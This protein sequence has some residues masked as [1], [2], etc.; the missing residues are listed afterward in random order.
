MLGL[1]TLYLGVKRYF[2]VMEMLT[3]NEYIL[4]KRGAW[5]ISVFSFLAILGALAALVLGR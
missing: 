4:N 2:E 5:F 3:S 1:A